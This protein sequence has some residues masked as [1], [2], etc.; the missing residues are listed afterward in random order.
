MGGR[1]GV[2]YV[3]ESSLNNSVISRSIMDGLDV[4]MIGGS[5]FTA[6]AEPAA[7]GGAGAAPEL[8]GAAGWANTN[9]VCPGSSKACTC[10]NW[11]L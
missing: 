3:S 10:L 5:V 1:R 4:G 6:G 7:P 11:N 9:C 2:A 8:A